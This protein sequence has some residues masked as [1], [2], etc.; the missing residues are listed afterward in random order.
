MEATHKFLNVSDAAAYLGVS[1]ASLRK[2][3]DQ[4]LVRVY[5]TPGGQRRY[6]PEDLDGFLASMRQPAVAQAV[7]RYGRTA[8][9]GT[10]AD[11]GPPLATPAP[12]SVRP[13]A[14]AETAADRGAEEH[15]HVGREERGGR[16]E[17]RR[18]RRAA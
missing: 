16:E 3:S 11:H 13:R 8:D 15:R 6:A 2:W 9:F 7:P 5:R 17:R 10:A 12:P 1:A 4:G 18:A 14:E